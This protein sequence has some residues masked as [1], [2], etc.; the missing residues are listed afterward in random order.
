[1]LSIKRR[2]I[3]TTSLKQNRMHL[4]SSKT[5]SNHCFTLLKSQR[6]IQIYIKVLAK[7]LIDHYKRSCL[8]WSIFQITLKL[9]KNKLKMAILMIIQAYKTLLQR[10]RIK[11]R[12]TMLK[13]MLLSHRLPP[14]LFIPAL[15]SSTLII[16]RRIRLDLYPLPGQ[17]LKSSRPINIGLKQGGQHNNYLN[18]SQ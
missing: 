2:I 18:L 10:H 14:C 15:N 16:T 9:L 13:Q 4:E 6:R 5:S 11:L 1:M 7:R 3:M 12:T 8:Y 17:S